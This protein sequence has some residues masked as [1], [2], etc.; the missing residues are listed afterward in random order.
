MKKQTGESYEGG[1]FA[2]MLT[3]AGAKDG[4]T[5]ALVAG[6]LGVLP[7]QTSG[8]IVTRPEN[9]HVITADSAALEGI[10]DF[11]TKSC[12][13]SKEALKFNVY[14]MQDDTKKAFASEQEYDGT[15]YNTLMTTLSEIAQKSGNGTHAIVAS[16][17][18]S[19]AAAILRSV[20]GPSGVVG[21]GGAMKK[22]VMDQN[23]WGLY[24][25][26]MGQ[27]QNYMQQDIWHCFW[28][29]HL[30]KKPSNDKD[31]AGKMIEKD[32]INVPG[33][34]G[35]GWAA[36]TDQVVRFRR[37][38]GQKWPGSKCDKTFM[39]TRASL[40]FTANGRGFNEKLDP[41]EPCLT[42]LLQKLGK[43]TGNWG[44]TSVSS[45][46]AAPLA[47]SQKSARPEYE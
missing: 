15:Y 44:A 28:E 3:V 4:K 20:S 1:K 47:K 38:H 13:G 34:T 26:M 17:L 23:K 21:H 14:N 24:G 32:S 35:N 16:S 40:D 29:A 10:Q 42:L 33:S 39:D 25:S 30:V 7:W 36:N 5:C 31:D 41:Q 8:G 45:K 18:T 27:F 22:S 6:A 19:F 12:G 46:K 9:L 11:I 37:Q 2:K 43:V